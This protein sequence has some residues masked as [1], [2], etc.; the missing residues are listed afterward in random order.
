[1]NATINAIPEGYD[2]VIPYLVVD[3]AAD[4][5]DFLTRAFEAKPI[6]T[7]RRS[8][9][10]LGHT[11]LTVCRSTV[12]LSDATAEW[13]A[14]PAR[15]FLYVDDVDARFALALRSGGAPVMEPADTDHGDRMA[16]VVDAG[17][18]EWWIASRIVNLS[19]GELQARMDAPAT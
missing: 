12:M 2:T 4:V 11:E 3:Q 19:P 15:V 10:T 1:M 14:M 7:L 6:M 8:D 9:G 13:A 16:C 5:V 18:N 17:G